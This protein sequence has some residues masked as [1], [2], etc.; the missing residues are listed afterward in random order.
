ML[1]L[2]MTFLIGLAVGAV[3]MGAAWLYWAQGQEWMN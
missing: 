2:I 1:N 3:A